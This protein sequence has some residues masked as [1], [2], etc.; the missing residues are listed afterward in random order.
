[1]API[2]EGSALKTFF[3]T[4]LKKVYERFL[5]IR[6]EP[7]D[8]ALGFALGL[9]VGLSP[10]MGLQTPV[11]IFFAA[12]LKWNKI[13][14]A[15]G[16]WI[17]NPLTAPIVYGITYFSGAKVLGLTRAYMPA[18]NIG[19]TS[20]FKMLLK[21]PEIFWALII[22]GLMIGIPLAVAGYYLS[23]SAVMRYQEKIKKKMAKRKERLAEKRKRRKKKKRFGRH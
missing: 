16:V 20:L 9:F 10:T 14:A 17:T 6:G 12:L 2:R 4:P 8:I 11:A 13:S 3:T 5:K 1:M 18:E 23:Y 7:R 21:A 19:S 22:G 15:L